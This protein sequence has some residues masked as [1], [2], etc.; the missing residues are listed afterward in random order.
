M[1]CA[2]VGSNP[3]PSTRLKL[4]RNFLNP[5]VGDAPNSRSASCLADP[6]RPLRTVFGSA[7][8]VP[9]AWCSPAPGFT[10]GVVSRTA[11]PSEL[12][13]RSTGPA[14]VGPP[15]PLSDTIDRS[16]T[17]R[18]RGKPH[19]QTGG[20]ARGREYRGA[21]GRDFWRGPRLKGIPRVTAQ[22]TTGQ[23]VGGTKH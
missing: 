17:S 5:T 1:A 19:R 6:Q 7:M 23:R 11:A 9:L 13:G 12:S 21:P 8:P 14:L 10:P 15:S 16:E 18:T 3:T 22:L 2:Y 4:L 20:M